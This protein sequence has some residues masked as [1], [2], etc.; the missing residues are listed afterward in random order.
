MDESE[1]WEEG[2]TVND[3]PYALQFNFPTS[4]IR[5]DPIPTRPQSPQILP[6]LPSPAPLHPEPYATK[7][8]PAPPPPNATHATTPT[9]I[10][11]P[12]PIY[13][14]APGY[15]SDGTYTSNLPSVQFWLKEYSSLSITTTSSGKTRMKKIKTPE[16]AIV[17]ALVALE[18]YYKPLH[19]AH[20]VFWCKARRELTA[21]TILKIMGE[22]LHSAFSS[23][24]TSEPPSFLSPN[25]PP[26][27]SHLPPSPIYR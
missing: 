12:Q 3:D 25:S 21:E 24:S 7:L 16:S 5:H 1:C 26:S 23:S 18:L 9:R 27:P 20:W 14:I 10:L 22:F 13:E 15:L 11:Y 19:P 6:T 4:C 2:F 17:Y 8:S